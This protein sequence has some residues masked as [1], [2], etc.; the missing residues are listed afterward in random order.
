MQVIIINGDGCGNYNA[1]VG[2]VTDVTYAVK[3]HP[4]DKVCL[5]SIVVMKVITIRD[6]SG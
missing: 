2:N 1:D 4:S 3:L 6:F 5:V